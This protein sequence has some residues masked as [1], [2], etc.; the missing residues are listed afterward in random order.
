MVIDITI[1]NIYTNRTERAR[2]V[3]RFCTLPHD[4]VL[5][6][7]SFECVGRLRPKPLRDSSFL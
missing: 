5:E 6:G 7:L 3:V 2:T 4:L 1:M